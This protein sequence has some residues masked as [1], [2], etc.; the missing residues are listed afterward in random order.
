MIKEFLHKALTQKASDIHI[1]AGLAPVFRI[2]G[3]LVRTAGAPL[4]EQDTLDMFQAITSSEQ[5]LYFH[6]NCEIDFAFAFDTNSRF[7]VNAYHQRG[8]VA[9]A[10]RIIKNQIASLQ[11]LGM[12]EIVKTLARMPRGLILVTGPTGSGKS[13]TLAA[14]IDLMNKERA[15][16]VLTLEEPIEYLYDQGTCVINQ[17]EIPTDSKS[18]ICSLKAALR[19]DPDVILV[20]EMRDAETVGTVMTA[21]ETGH[22]VLATLHTYDCAQSID[23]IIDVFPPYQQA[24]IRS[25]LSLTLQGI[26]AQQLLPRQDGNGRV[27]AVETLIATPAV[28]NLIREGKTHQIA[29]CIQTGARYGMQAMDF[30]LQSLYQQGIISYEAALGYSMDKENFIRLANS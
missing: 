26:I 24:Q 28:R 18:F 22:L 6:N 8:A 15:L 25:Q 9:M 14:M 2:N 19:E 7:R 16:H 4:T 30:S 20:G 11:E 17:R 13:T 27:V 3:R 23:R 29:S 1:T 5:Q 12:P 10:I 21:A